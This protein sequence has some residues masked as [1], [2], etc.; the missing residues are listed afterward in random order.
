LSVE[1]KK[2]F[3]GPVLPLGRCPAARHPLCSK[4]GSGL[5]YYFSPIVQPAIYEYIQ[6]T[7]GP[8]QNSSQEVTKGEREVLGSQHLDK[9]TICLT[10]THTIHHTIPH[11]TPQT[12]TNYVPHSIIIN[13]DKINCEII[14]DF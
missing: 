5:Y 11:M 7:T 10:L 1:N 4:A 6:V 9:K 2:L 3:N 14:L 12:T 8:P 13:I